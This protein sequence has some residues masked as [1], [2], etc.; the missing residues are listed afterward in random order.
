M[1]VLR[2]VGVWSVLWCALLSLPAGVTAGRASW[3][4]ASAAADRRRGG[5]TEPRGLPSPEKIVRGHVNAAG[6]KKKLAGVRDAAYE[7]AIL[8]GGREAGSARTLTKDPGSARIEFMP[9][10]GPASEEAATPRT[11]WRREA[12]GAARTL[13]D[14]EA[15]AAKLLALLG[16]LDFL[17]YKKQNVLA[18]TV[19]VAEAA[20]ASA[21]VVEFTRREGGRLRYSFDAASGLL[22]EV[23]DEGGRVLRRF[24]DYRPA[25]PAG[26]PLIPHRVEVSRAGSGPLALV[27]R[28]ARFNTGLADSLFDPPGDASLDVAPLLREVESNQASSDERL[29]DYTFTLTDTKLEVSDRGEVRSRKVK[30]FEVYP[31]AGGGSARKLVSDDGVPLAPERLAKEERRVA[32]ELERAER[33]AREGRRRADGEADNP[34]GPDDEDIDVGAFLRACEFVSPRRE[35]FRGREAVVF[36]FRP[37]RGYKPKGFFELVISKSEGVMWVD[38]ADKQVVRL[39]A[40][41]PERYKIA[42]GL[43]ATVGRGTG[44]VVERTRLADGVWAPRFERYSGSFKVLLLAGVRVDGT[45]EYGDYRRFDASSGDAVLDPPKDL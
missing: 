15:G 32:G 21:Y 25:A 17:D 16:A 12:G 28:G 24:G 38:P 30:V 31:L 26:G 4:G 45:R 1:R 13:T 23:A 3:P 11:A 10:G 39:E 9:E 5:A 41:L 42:G 44:F 19:G 37:R 40:R 34:R 29:A 20:G 36:D 6:G 27:L 22:S 2:Q 33:K 7:W 14:E 8:D 35:E 18:R 43:L